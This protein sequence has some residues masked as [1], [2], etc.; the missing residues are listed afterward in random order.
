MKALITGGSG[1]IGSFLAENLIE[2]GHSVIAL[3]NL[4]TGFYSNLASLTDNKKFSFVKGDVMDE[5][6]VDDL[7]SQSDNVF[8][9]AAAVGVKRIVDDP[10]GSIHTNFE[11]TSVVLEAAN[12]NKKNVLFLEKESGSNKSTDYNFKN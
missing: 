8:H 10:V 6:L 5:N 7:V 12:I 2:N 9:L 11:T 4:S 3:D 1:F